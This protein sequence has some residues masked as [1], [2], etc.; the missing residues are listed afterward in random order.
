MSYSKISFQKEPRIDLTNYKTLE[1]IPV[2][3]AKGDRQSYGKNYAAIK[4]DGY[5]LIDD[6]KQG[7]DGPKR[8]GE[9]EKYGW[10]LHISVDVEQLPEAW[11]II[12]NALMK[13]KITGFKVLAPEQVKDPVKVEQAAIQKKQVTIYQFK[14]KG[15]SQEQ[16][17][18]VIQEIESSL[19]A[20]GIRP[21]P[22]PPIANKEIEGSKYFAYRND[23]SANKKSYIGDEDAV[24]IANAS[25]DRNIKDYNP[26]NFNNDP[27][28]H[29]KLNQTLESTA[30]VS[31]SSSSSTS[32]K[33]SEDKLST[34][35]ARERVKADRADLKSGVSHENKVG[36]GYESAQDEDSSDL[37]P[38]Q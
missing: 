29:I 20:A 36:E 13:N 24:A 10:K 23:S 17:L 15:V 31:S 35:D 33:P 5:V 9:I 16:W 8:I 38:R 25:K 6:Q 22:I 27:F 19:K 30:T 1:T 4:R 34:A 26:S 3:G 2:I 18:A 32:I 28:E 37:S 11:S 7:T 21:V 14:N 12:S